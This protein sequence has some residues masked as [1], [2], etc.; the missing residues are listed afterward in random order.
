MSP[1]LVPS[2]AERPCREHDLICNFINQRFPTLL[3]GLPAPLGAGL[4][5]FL[6]LPGRFGVVPLVSALASVKAEMLP[7]DPAAPSLRL[8]GCQEG[9]VGKDGKREKSTSESLE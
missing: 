9:S 8:P 7:W 3:L 6:L 2:E 1:G 4:F 5:E